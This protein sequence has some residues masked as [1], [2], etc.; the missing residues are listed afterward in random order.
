MHI[1]VVLSFLHPLWAVFLWIYNL[2][3]LSFAMN[4]D[5]RESLE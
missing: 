1:E 3:E 5:L 4:F 2:F